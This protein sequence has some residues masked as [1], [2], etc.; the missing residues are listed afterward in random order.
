M[1]KKRYKVCILAFL[2]VDAETEAKAKKEAEFQLMQFVNE[3]QGGNT[4]AWGSMV[5]FPHPANPPSKSIIEYPD[6][7]PGGFDGP[8]GAE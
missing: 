7:Y 2:D 1:K 6:D 5:A 3:Q 8:T 4:F